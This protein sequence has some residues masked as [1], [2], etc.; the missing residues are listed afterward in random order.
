MP[1]T[2][3]PHIETRPDGT[4]M[5]DDTGFKVVLLVMAH[6]THG[7]SADELARQFPSLSLGQ[8]HGALAYYYDHESELNA[9]IERRVKLEEQQ[10]AG[11]KESALRAPLR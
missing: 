8:I 10:F 6:L 5:I 11:V 1:A 7:W 3:Y 2:G 4:L 9:E